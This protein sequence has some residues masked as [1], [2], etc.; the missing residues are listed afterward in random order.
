M[1][2]EK[3]DS[4]IQFTLETQKQQQKKIALKK[5]HHLPEFVMSLF[6]NPSPHLEHEEVAKYFSFV[7][8]IRK[9]ESSSDMN[10]YVN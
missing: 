5:P 8:S 9:L 2:R 10:V 6:L 1:S 4:M 7:N 3:V